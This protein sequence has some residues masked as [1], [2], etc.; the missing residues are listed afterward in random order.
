MSLGFIKFEKQN[1]T[2]R[3]WRDGSTTESLVSRSSGELDTS[4]LLRLLCPSAQKDRHNTQT[5]T[6]NFFFFK[7]SLYCYPNFF[8]TLTPQFRKLPLSSWSCPHTACSI[9]AVCWV[10]GDSVH[11][12]L[13]SQYH[14]KQLLPDAVL[15]SG[16]SPCLPQPALRLSNTETSQ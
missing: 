16:G 7:D 6:C 8:L 10:L 5:D 14:W 12:H 11:S 13:S 1:E 2:S 3:S 15:H 9:P 4:D